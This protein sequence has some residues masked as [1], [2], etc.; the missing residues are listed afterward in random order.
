MDTKVA[1]RTR[2]VEIAASVKD[3][4]SENILIVANKISEYIIGHANIPES[5]DMQNFIKSLTDATVNAYD[6]SLK[7]Q[8]PNLLGGSATFGYVAPK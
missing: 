7:K 5:L 2:A 3:V 1:I 8:C 6:E 4:N